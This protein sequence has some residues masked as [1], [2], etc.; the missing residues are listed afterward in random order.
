MTVVCAPTIVW[1]SQNLRLLFVPAGFDSTLN[2]MVFVHIVPDVTGLHKCGCDRRSTSHTVR[3]CI[4]ADSAMSKRRKESL[5]VVPMMIPRDFF[6]YNSL[7]SKRDKEIGRVRSSH[8]KDQTA[9][10]LIHSQVCCQT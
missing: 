6:L 5:S 4:C 8:Q 7:G 2:A 10:K 1:L 9:Q 3:S